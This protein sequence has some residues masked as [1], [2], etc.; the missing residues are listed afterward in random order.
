MRE[1]GLLI[2]FLFI[3]KLQQQSSQQ[4]KNKNNQNYNNYKQTNSQPTRTTKHTK[5]P[6]IYYANQL[7][8]YSWNH[9]TY[10]IMISTQDQL[11]LN[12]QPTLKLSTTQTDNHNRSKKEILL[13]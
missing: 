5:P 13:Q 7:T 6:P 9:F 3:G 4:Q 12:E 1:L 2:F 10:G 8:K 11:K